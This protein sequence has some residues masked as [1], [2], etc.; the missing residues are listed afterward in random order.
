ML[1]FYI[2]ASAVITLFSGVVTSSGS[3]YKTPLT[4]IGAFLGFIALHAIVFF[5]S[6]YICKTGSKFYRFVVKHT[7]PIVVTLLRVEVHITGEDKIPENERFLLVCNHTHNIDPA[8][9]LYA[10]PS[11]ELSFIGK[12]EIETLM[13]MVFRIFS[14]LGGI[15]IDRENNRE[16]AKAIIKAC[17]LIKNDEASVG[18]FPEGYTSMDGN[19]QPLRNGALKIATKT[20]SKIAVCT[21][22]GTKQAIDRIFIRKNHIYFD[23]LE[24]IDTADNTHTNELGDRVHA[25]M[26]ENIEK[27]RGE[28]KN[29]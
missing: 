6:T 8:I 22:L 3:L 15:P 14:N 5:A 4:L 16:G 17:N 26:A 24:V 9:I 28:E 2:V 23:I 18:I 19:L 21:L 25:L 10:L 27:R 13:P 11:A 29:V 1:Y 12:K 7:L 20:G